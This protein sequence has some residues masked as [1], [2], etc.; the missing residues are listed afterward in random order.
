M[1]TFLKKYFKLLALG[2]LSLVACVF[3]LFIILLIVE[4]FGVSEEATNKILDHRLLL[5]LLIFASMFMAYFS[6]YKK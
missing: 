5:V 4:G 1:Q 2:V 6:L 3:V